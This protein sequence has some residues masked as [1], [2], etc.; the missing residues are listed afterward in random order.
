[1][2]LKMFLCRFVNTSLHYTVIITDTGGS[3]LITHHAL[4]RVAISLQWSHDIRSINADQ[5][6]NGFPGREVLCRSPLSPVAPLGRTAGLSAAL[7][8][9]ES[10][11]YACG[12][13]ICVHVCLWYSVVSVCA[14]VISECSYNRR[15]VHKLNL[16][17]HIL[18]FFLNFL[19]YSRK[20]TSVTCFAFYV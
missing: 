3:Y 2:N 13:N 4:A 8:Q 18:F 11:R 20:N 14:S 10:S 19:I 16:P 5:T 12:A 9:K 6:L 15:L 17:E 1:M 7:A